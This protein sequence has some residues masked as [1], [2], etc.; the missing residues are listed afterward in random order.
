MGKFI[1]HDTI[2][3]TKKSFWYFFWKRAF[4]LFFSF[5]F[6]LLFS[7]F[8]IIIGLLVFFTNPGHIIFFDKRIGKKG[9]VISVWKFRSMYADSETRPEKYLNEEQLEQWKRERKVL[10]DPRITPFG[11]FLRKTSIDELPQFI[12]IFIGNMSFVG[13]RPITAAEIE[14]NFTEQQKEVLFQAKPGLTG[15]WQVSGRSDVTWESGDRQK[16]ELQY[17]QTRSLGK[18]L[19]ILFKTVPAVLNKK[20]AH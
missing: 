1:E 9:K 19:A 11:R 4:D 18:D 8:L 12:N 20:G 16:L 2:K 10:N 3:A 7:W 13:P 6:L 14:E 5:L 17:L 15:L